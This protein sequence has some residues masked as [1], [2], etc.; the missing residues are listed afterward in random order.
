MNLKKR[1]V[2]KKPKELLAICEQPILSKT[3]TN[4]NVGKHTFEV[5]RFYLKMKAQLLLKL[6]A[7]DENEAFEKPTQL[8][9]K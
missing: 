2:L 9:K 4:V 7:N 8:G 6:K 1:L 5:D 3:R